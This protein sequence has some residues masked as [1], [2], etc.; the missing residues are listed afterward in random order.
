M[1]TATSTVELRSGAGVHRIAA[2]FGVF[3]GVHLGHRRIVDRVL[4]L[5]RRADAVPTVITFSTHPRVVVS[6]DLPP[7]LLT[8]LPQRLRLLADAG[9]QGAVLLPFGPAM[10][11]M[12]PADF[13]QTC[14][15]ADQGPEVVALCV[16]SAWR[17]GKGGSGSVDTLMAVAA[18]YGCHVESVPEVRLDGQPVSSTRIRGEILAGRLASAARLLGHP[19]AVAGIVTHGKGIGQ[20]RLDCPTANIQDPDIVLPPSGVYAARAMRIGRAGCLPGIAYVGNSPTFVPAAALPSARIVELHLFGL[21][22]ALYGEEIEVEF[23]ALLRGDHRFRS[24]D[25]LKAQIVRDIAAARQLL[26]LAPT[27]RH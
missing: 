7:R 21:A 4:D 8:T 26:G 23:V 16:G 6:S 3:D 24:A 20:A 2:A 25:E 13:L 15:F 5:A 12:A 17:F 10:A 14:V 11:A 9:I 1:N 19:F 27:S 22:E 18:P